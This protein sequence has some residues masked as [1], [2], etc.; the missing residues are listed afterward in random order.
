[1]AKEKPQS[2]PRAV[3]DQAL[4]TSISG[5][6]SM[7]KAA[8]KTRPSRSGIVSKNPVSDLDTLMLTN[9]LASLSYGAI[10]SFFKCFGVVLRIR[11][12]YDSDCR[13][14]RCY[15][16]FNTNAA[17]KAAFEAKDSLTVGDTHCKVQM[18]RSTNVVDSDNDYCPNIFEDSV[19]HVPKVRWVPTP[20]WFVAYYRE[21]RGNLIHASRYLEKEIGL[22]PMCHIKK[23]GK[24]VLIRAKD[25]TQAMMLL[26]LP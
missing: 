14:I 26:N 19:E 8:N 5:R 16:T 13:S 11:I 2:L 1:M 22:L 20:F 7:K 24:G 3:V 6:G 10:H 9:V 15:I 4:E 17:A 25:L 18:M 23:Y 12:T 21:G